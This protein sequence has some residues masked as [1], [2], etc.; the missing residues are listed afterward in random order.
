[1][2][3]SIDLL[4]EIGLESSVRFAQEQADKRR[5]KL[6]NGLRMSLV[7]CVPLAVLLL[8]QSPPSLLKLAQEE[9]WAGRD[10]LG[11]AQT[12]AKTLANTL[13]SLDMTGNQSWQ[14]FGREEL[15]HAWVEIGEPVLN[16][17]RR[18]GATIVD[19]P[20]FQ[21]LAIRLSVGEPALDPMPVASIRRPDETAAMPPSR[22]EAQANSANSDV[23]LTLARQVLALSPLSPRA[24]LVLGQIL[25]ERDDEEGLQVLVEAADHD[26]RMVAQVQPKIEAF[27]ERHMFSR[28]AQKS[29]ERMAELAKAADFALAER[30]TIN[31]YDSF[32]APSLA[33]SRRA[34]VEACFRGRNEI[35]SARIAAK[36]VVRWTDFPAYVV[37]LDLPVE[38]DRAHD[39]RAE[40]AACLEALEID[41]TVEVVTSS[42]PRTQI[43]LSTLASIEGTIVYHRGG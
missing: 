30:R 17:M 38:A 18:I 1:M 16:D 6:K 37:I 34:D 11:Y 23:S 15:S 8:P 21:A 35:A 20:A 5:A 29:R 36:R 3:L 41:G 26:P 9:P 40:V 27:A 42:D 2:R 31:Q 12:L 7:A 10:T 14:A 22:I 28:A 39:V 24:R 25:L 19:M 13:V 43:H 33:S 4:R 32:L